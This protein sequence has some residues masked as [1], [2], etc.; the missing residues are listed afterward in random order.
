MRLKLISMLFVSAA[1]FGCGG[2]T[3]NSAPIQPRFAATVQAPAAYTDIVQRIYVAYFGRPADTSGLPFFNQHLSTANAPTG[4]IDLVNAY[5]ANP[6]IREI[7]NT[8]GNSPESNQLYSGG[9]E[10][11]VTAIYRNLF[12]REP[13]A[14]GLAFWVNNI[15][16]G[17]MTR[18]SAA[19]TIMAGAAGSDIAI[20][21]NKT[22]AATT[23]TNSLDTPAK[24]AGYGDLAAAATARTMLLGV[25]AATS[26]SAIET[27]VNNTITT[28]T[29]S[30]NK[31]ALVQTIVKNR[32]VTCHS[33]NPSFPGMSWAPGGVVYDSAEQ[34]RAGA[35]LLYQTAVISRSMPDLNNITD[36]TEAERATITEWIEA[37]AP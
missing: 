8:F 5:H 17:N 10:A 18:A 22:L 1:L 19:I 14:G 30:V 25:D 12:N 34:I 9:N 26:A 11:F 7:V 37:G 20:V 28:L 4:V 15:N 27:A 36:M 32:C 21:T 24:I 35:G 6:A 23:F 13:D 2:Q 31:F 33:A 16:N 3:Q 29:N